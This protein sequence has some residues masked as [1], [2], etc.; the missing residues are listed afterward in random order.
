MSQGTDPEERSDASRVQ[1]GIEGLRWSPA[2]RGPVEPPQHHDHDDEVAND[3]LASIYTDRREQFAAAVPFIEQGLERGERCLYVADENSEEAVLAAMRNRG[4]DV[5][6]AIDSGQLSI[7]TKADTYLRTGDFDRGAMVEFW[8]DTLRRAKDEEGYAGVRAAAEMTW[9]LDG[10]ASL[11]ELT[12]YEAILNTVYSGEDYAVLCQY[13][14]ERFPPEVVR[15]VVRTHPHLIADSTV[16]H[17]V[18]YTPPEEYFGPDDAAREVDRMMGTLRE[19]TEVKTELKE[20]QRYLR[21]QNEITASPDRT[22]EEKLQALFELGCERFDLELGAMAT[23]DPETDRFEIEYTSGDH[24]H[25]EPGFELPLSETYC[26]AATEAKG[27]ASVSDPR[28]DGYDDVTVNRKFGLKAY[29]GTYVEVD[30]DFDRTFF[31]VSSQSRSEPFSDEERSFNRLL[32]QWVKYELERRQRERHQR[33][34]YEITADADRTFE[35]KLQALFELGCE[36]FDLEL[37]G[38]ARIDPESDHFEVETISGD[39]EHLV[40]GAQVALSE[41]YCRVFVDETDVK[42]I[43]DPLDSGFQGTLAYEEF[44]VKAYLGTRL[45]LDDGPDRTLFFVSTEPRERGFSEA[46][47]TFHHL[48]GQWV[49]YE[50]ERSNREEQLESKNERLESFASMLAHELRNPVTI[51]QIYGQQLPDEADSTAVEHVTDAFDRIEN[52][53]DVMLVLTRDR[54]AI[55]ECSSVRLADAAREAWDDVDTPDATL[56]VGVGCAIPT[57]ETYVRHL[58]RNLFENSVEHGGSDVTVT[59]GDLPDGFY[60]EDDGVGIPESDREDVFE[61][62]YTTASNGGGTGLGLAF[63]RELADTYGWSCGVTESEAGGVRFEFRNVD[64]DTS[65]A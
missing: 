62:G 58:F 54:E 56:D 59:V 13:N 6:A 53:I 26:T 37:G 2:L 3:H 36:R 44:G 5:D 33:A 51:G 29:L 22:F 34:L 32:G 45:E 40:P 25:F 60:V 24:E 39:H 7:H 50:L 8:E 14:R 19:R 63:V 31:F 27:P 1:S 30:G 52:I 47:R 9:A 57:D 15:D 35:E 23:V 49:Q 11:D 4:V 28:A 48:M 41:T 18:Y 20:R 42:G 17:N 38:L 16:Y 55:D 61:A 46:E 12:E 10:D 64:A 43:T 21:K 65:D